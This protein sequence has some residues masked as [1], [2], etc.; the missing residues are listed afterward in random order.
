MRT[1][2][3]A[4]L[5]RKTTRLKAQIAA[6]GRG[7]TFDQRDPQEHGRRRPRQIGDGEA[8]RV[9]DGTSVE[10]PCLC[11]FFNV[12]ACRSRACLF[13]VCTE[14]SKPKGVS[15]CVELQQAG[16]VCVFVRTH[17]YITKA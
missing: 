9:H 10:V 14:K 11:V 15:R 16:A 1:H 4:F 12:C 7:R 2:R 17:V 13:F 6:G 3:H 8:P 5:F